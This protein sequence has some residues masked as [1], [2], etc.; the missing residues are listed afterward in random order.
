MDKESEF[1]LLT[2]TDLPG[3][4]RLKDVLG[5]AWGNEVRAGKK[6]GIVAMLRPSRKERVLELQELAMQARKKAIK[7]MIAAAKEMGANGVI[8]VRLTG[9]T[10]EHD[11]VEFIAYG[12]AVSV[13][14]SGRRKK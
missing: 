10:F 8:G 9:F 6:E 11:I 3:G 7:R 5:M 12:T 2:T 13:T 1:L 14:K 4:Y